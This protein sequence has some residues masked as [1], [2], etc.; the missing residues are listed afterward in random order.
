MTGY[1]VC[2]PDR[3]SLSSRP[4]KPVIPAAKICHPDRKNLSSRPQKSVIPTVVEGSQPVGSKLA[5]WHCQVSLERDPSASLRMTNYGVVSGP[6][7]LS[8]RPQKSVIPTV[9]E[10][11]QPVGRKLAA[12]HCQVPLEKGP[13]PSLRMTNYGV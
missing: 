9:V 7:N 4:E 2:Y 11:S 5:A 10:G 13:S 12:W 1:G 8:S 6:Q 3:H